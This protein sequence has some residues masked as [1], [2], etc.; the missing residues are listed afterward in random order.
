MK[1]HWVYILISDR[2]RRYIGSTS[3]LE[4][5]I[6]QHSRKH[7]GFT[8]TREAWE[9]EIAVECESILDARGLES[10]LKSFKNS[11]KAIEYLKKAQV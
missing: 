2:G 7:K 10:K 8:G 5:R 1:K 4:Q 11:T 3:N 6:S 9:L